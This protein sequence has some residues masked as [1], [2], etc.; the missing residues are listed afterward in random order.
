MITYDEK[1]VHGR[2]MVDR[3]ISMDPKGLLGKGSEKKRI[4]YGLFFQK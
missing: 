2:M 3:K 4:F 1:Y